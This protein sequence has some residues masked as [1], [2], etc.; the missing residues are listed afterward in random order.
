MS[1]AAFLDLSLTGAMALMALA[2]FLGL[3]RLWKG[4]TLGDRV[5]ALD[6]MSAAVIGFCALFALK[7]G[8]GAYLDIA[9]AVALVSFVPV[10]ALARYAERLARREGTD[11]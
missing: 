4:P 9:V 1:S 11:D 3:L 2:V 10:V 8:I 6:M 7:A 5:V